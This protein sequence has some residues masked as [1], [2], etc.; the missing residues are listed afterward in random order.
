MI[1]ST[2]LSYKGKDRSLHKYGPNN[3]NAVRCVLF[4]LLL[5]LL[6]L[7]AGGYRLS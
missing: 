3:G 4:L 7:A 2:A 6:L 5:L 1:H